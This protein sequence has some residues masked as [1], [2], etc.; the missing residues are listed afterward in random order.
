MHAQS[1]VLSHTSCSLLNLY[2][3]FW[4]RDRSECG[5][6]RFPDCV[7]WHQKI[8]SLEFQTCQDALSRN[9]STFQTCNTKMSLLEPKPECLQLSDW[10][11]T[12]GKAPGN[13][14]YSC[15][16]S[17]IL[18][19]CKNYRVWFKWTICPLHSSAAVRT[20]FPPQH[21]QPR[22]WFLNFFHPHRTG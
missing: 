20:H 3:G 1:R 8:I 16:L 14:S 12:D 10:Q 17:K 2:F 15:K 22:G 6:R 7:A 4:Q 11:K 9:C 18:Y 19:C 13:F 21:E 5:V